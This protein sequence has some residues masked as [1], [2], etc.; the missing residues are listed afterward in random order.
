MPSGTE[1]KKSGKLVQFKYS[2]HWVNNIVPILI[3]KIW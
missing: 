3:S 2:L 1:K